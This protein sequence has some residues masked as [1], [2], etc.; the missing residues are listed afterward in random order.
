MKIEVVL[1]RAAGARPGPRA[2]GYRGQLASALIEGFRHLRG[3][4]R[5][6]GNNVYVMAGS[7]EPLDTAQL[8]VDMARIFGMGIIHHD[9]K[10]LTG[11]DALKAAAAVTQAFK[12][13]VDDLYRENQ[14]ITG[15]FFVRSAQR[16]QACLHGFLRARWTVIPVV[17]E[18]RADVAAQS[19]PPIP[20]SGALMSPVPGVPSASPYMARQIA[21]GLLLGTGF[22]VLI[23]CGAW[24]AHLKLP[25][26]IRSP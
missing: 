18:S 25:T 7:G 21:G 12:D 17:I 26:M 16:Y 10:I 15:P 13:A 24:L 23:G 8:R 14:S 9:R 3:D 1:P 5:R 4:R 11:R 20:R 19:L 2:P 6:F 22:I